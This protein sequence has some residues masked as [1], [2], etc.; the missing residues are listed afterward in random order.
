LAPHF[1]NGGNGGEVVCG[2]IG[3]IIVL[4]AGAIWRRRKLSQSAEH[5]APA[6]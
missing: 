2:I 6:G 4:V 1:A 5:A 3:I